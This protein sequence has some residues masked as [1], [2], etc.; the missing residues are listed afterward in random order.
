MERNLNR[1]CGDTLFVFISWGRLLGAASYDS[2]DAMW[3]PQ[4]V[5]SRPFFIFLAMILVPSV[6]LLPCTSSHRRL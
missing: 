3:S 5:R 1:L 2:Y 6:L 4:W